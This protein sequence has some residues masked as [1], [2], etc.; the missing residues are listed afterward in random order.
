MDEQENRAQDTNTQVDKVELGDNS[1]KL[2]AKSKDS[3]GLGRPKIGDSRPAPNTPETG[4][5]GKKKRKRRRSRS[6]NSRSENL[7]N[8][9][10]ELDDET[11]KKRRG[12]ERKGKAVGRYTMVVHVEDNVTQIAMLEGRSLIEFYV[13]RPADDISEI[14]GN[15]Y[16]G[17]VE[18]VLP[19]MEAAFVD[20]GTPKNA[21]LYQSDLIKNASS[22]SNETIRIEEALKNK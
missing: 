13:S 16:L 3:S 15:I 5:Q 2:E 19:G 4:A 6:G 20:I 8:V 12:R 22:K 1:Q 11:L 18:N 9:S 17:R 14:H 7:A 10:V 21:V